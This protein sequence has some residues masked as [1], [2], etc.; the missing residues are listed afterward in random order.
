MLIA[1]NFLEYVICWALFFL[2]AR[3]V[4]K[5]QPA[6]ADFALAA[7]DHYMWTLKVE[8]IKKLL[9]RL[10]LDPT[11]LTCTTYGALFP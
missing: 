10:E 4:L 5:Y 3:M 7:F 1:I 9:I 6:K 11:V 2:N 8:V